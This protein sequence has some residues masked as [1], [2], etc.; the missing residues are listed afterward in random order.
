MAK[1]ITLVPLSAQHPDGRPP[2][3]L[4]DADAKLRAREELRRRLDQASAENAEALLALWKLL[5]AAHQHH[6]LEIATGAIASSADIITRLADAGATEPAIRGI[7]NVLLLSELLGSLDPEA[8][9]ALVKHLPPVTTQAAAEFK[10]AAASST[11]VKAA[12]A[13]KPPSL[14]QIFRRLTSEDSRRALGLIA[15]L[16]AAL[17]RSLRPA[18]K[19][20]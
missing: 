2:A 5:E 14:W 11:A 19:Q 15:G 18:K 10:A 3:T 20:Q 6:V 17:G 8:L 9:H 1:A 13:D 16:T 12:E 4:S 7:R